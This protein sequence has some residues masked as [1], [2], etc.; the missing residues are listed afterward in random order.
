MK[1]NVFY[2]AAMSLLLCGSQTFAQVNAM[3][4]E[5]RCPANTGERIQMKAERVA[6]RLM[7]DDQTAAR[8][9]PMYESYLKE[10]QEC[11]T[12]CPRMKRRL[13]RAPRMYIRKYSISVFHINL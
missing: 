10:L 7:L 8:F 1:M 11:R 13:Y 2:V 5:K 12:E 4:G 9:K 3:H 6:D